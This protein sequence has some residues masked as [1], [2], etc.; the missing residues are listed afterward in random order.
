[1]LKRKERKKETTHLPSTV[2]GLPRQD[3]IYLLKGKPREMPF[4]HFTDENS[5]FEVT[6]T[7]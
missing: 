3:L 7:A 6:A 5:E 4:H 2:V 1:M